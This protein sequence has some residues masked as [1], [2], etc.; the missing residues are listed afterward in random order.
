V[1]FDHLRIGIAPRLSDEIRMPFP[2]GLPVPFI[3]EGRRIGGHDFQPDRVPGARG[4]GRAGVD[5]RS[6]TAQLSL[7]TA[8]EGQRQAQAVN[9]L[10]VER[11]VDGVV[12]NCVLVGKTICW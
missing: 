8:F 4:L 2:D 9:V 3:S 6:I 11:L 10:G 12:E 7:M 1:D 5:E